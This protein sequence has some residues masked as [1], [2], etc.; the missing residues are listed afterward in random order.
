MSS[1]NLGNESEYVE[2]KA[3]TA[4]TTSAIESIVAML[5]KHGKA[6]VYF[7]VDDNGEVIGQNIGNKTIRDLS[8][9]ITSEIKPSI[10]PTIAFQEY[11]GKIVIV[12]FA[13]GNNKPY[14][15][16]GNYRIRSGC[17]NKKIEPELLR[18]LVFSNSS[19]QITII[20]SFNQELTFS[21]LKQLY[22]LNGLTIDND[23]FEKNTGLLCENGK[24]NI[25]ADILSD[26]NDI[27]IK[28]VR[29]KGKDKSEMIVRNEYGYKCLLL[30]MQKALDY[31]E[32]FNE[33]KVELSGKLNR[34][35]CQ[36]FS[37]ECLREAWVNA[38]LHTKWSK[39]IPPAI[40]IYSDRIEIISTGGLPIDYSVDDFY[41]GISCPINKQLQKIMGQLK[42]IEGTGHGVPEIINKYGKKAFR[43]TENNI[44]VTLPFNFSFETRFNDRLNLSLSTSHQKV[45][46]AIKNHPISKITEISNVTG[47]SEPRVSQIIRDLKMLNLIKRT[48]ANKNGYYEIL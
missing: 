22:I 5:N 29:F 17:T 41:L 2:F 39:L 31:V 38:C 28:V 8:E 47:L 20:P 1:V 18:E 26:N 19:E 48:G 10:I 27:S 25:L 34:E 3:S 40:Y 32:T 44:I 23:T 33:T 21:Q 45:L 11:D 14:S 15:A 46:N 6:K 42:I 43:I 13:E 9:S 35:E 12:V 36:R 30:S 16:N 4:Q 24:Y 37:P 7:G